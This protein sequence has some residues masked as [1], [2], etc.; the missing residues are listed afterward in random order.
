MTNFEQNLRSK[1]TFV[2]KWYETNMPDDFQHYLDW[3]SGASRSEIA[4]FESTTHL[5]LPTDLRVL[6]E[7]CNGT[8]P[9]DVFGN[10]V[11]LSLSDSATLKNTLDGIVARG[12]FAG[13]DEVAVP[14]GSIRK[15]W[16]SPKWI[17]VLDTGGGPTFCVDLDP[18]EGGVKGQFIEVHHATGPIKVL[19]D[20]LGDFVCY[21]AEELKKGVY[22][23]DSESCSLKRVLPK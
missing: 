12:E 6:W 3:Q 10:G 1:W 13:D 18:A 8:Y 7:L 23:F 14:I 11:L 21:F 9:L 20:S 17:P 2:R 15:V 19:A 4:E 16:W 22:R 5:S